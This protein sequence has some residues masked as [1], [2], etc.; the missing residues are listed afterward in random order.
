MYKPHVLKNIQATGSIL[1]LFY[2]MLFLQWFMSHHEENVSNLQVTLKSKI[3]VSKPNQLKIK[4]STKM[5]YLPLIIT[6]MSRLQE[7]CTV[8]STFHVTLTRRSRSTNVFSCKCIFSF[9]VGCSN[10]K[11][12]LCIGHMMSRVL[13]IILCDLD[14]KVKVK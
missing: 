11:L 14:S 7:C 3:M 10:I 12:S 5:F 4:R 13:G 8:S 6:L 1:C 9:S 2:K